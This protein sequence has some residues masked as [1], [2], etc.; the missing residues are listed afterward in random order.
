MTTIAIVPAR[1]GSKGLPG[2]NIAR[3]ADKTLLELAVKVGVDCDAVDSV[4]VSTDVPLY[5][6]IALAA[7]ACSLGLRP[8][9]LAN[10]SAKTVD[11]VIDLVSQIDSPIENIVVLQPTAPMRTPKDVCATLD[12]L[13]QPDTSAVVAVEAIDEPHPA[14]T[15]RVDKDGFIGPF[16][17]NWSSETPRQQLP[18]AYRL[19]GAIYT[20]SFVS[21]VEERTLL[22]KWTRPYVMP[23]GINIDREWDLLL[24]R[25]LIDTGRVRIYGA[26]A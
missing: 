20:T 2:K 22:P 15:K 12:L 26:N 11:V 8:H 7:G 3:I 24:L 18:I 25:T 16:C 21:L 9:H 19:S 17:D 1:S 10:D 6:R 14:K 4:F 23:A 13:S 5:E